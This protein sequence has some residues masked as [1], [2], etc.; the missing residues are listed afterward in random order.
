MAEELEIME[1]EMTENLGALNIYMRQISNIPEI[2]KDEFKTLSEMLKEPEQRE[3]AKNRIVEGN[4]RLVV[5]LAH[6]W[7]NIGLGIDDLIAEGNVG[8]ME[9][10]E[11]FN[12]AI[13]QSFASYASWYI[14]VKMS[15]AINKAKIV[16][17]PIET[18]MNQR[19][20]KRA[21]ADFKNENGREP[22][23][24]EI[25]SITGMSK[26]KQNNVKNI[27]TSVM[28]INQKF[29]ESDSDSDEIGDVLANQKTDS[30]LDIMIHQED[31]QM[32]RNALKKLDERDRIILSMR[33]GL[34]NNEMATLEKVSTVVGKT[35]ERCRQIEKE[36]LKKLQKLIEEELKKEA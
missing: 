33:Y 32:V 29:D 3:T 34:L 23:E 17:T 13:G 4:L 8:L 7:K 11:K 28:S 16:R 10:I 15:R 12:P 1:T 26:Y 5:A 20:Y 22:T 36:A 6:K 35:R 2:T 30:I 18:E 14:N 27:D 21:I 9:A 19:R 24:E 25:E 31:I